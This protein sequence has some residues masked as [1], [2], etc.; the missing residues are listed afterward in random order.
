MISLRRLNRKSLENNN[1]DIL[2]INFKIHFL[3]FSR[4]SY[5]IF[6]LARMCLWIFHRNIDFHLSIDN[7]NNLIQS[8][9]ISNWNLARNGKL[10]VFITSW[11]QLWC[12][13]IHIHKLKMSFNIIKRGEHALTA[14]TINFIYS[15]F[16]N[17]VSHK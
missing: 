16:M 13:M 8:A 14:A 1:N 2:I 4:F 11:W 12:K 7:N 15:H 10:R 9:Y 6:N 17:V 5:N 3:K